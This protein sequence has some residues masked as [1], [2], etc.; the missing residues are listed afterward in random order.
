M[1]GGEKKG[2]GEGVFTVS[3]GDSSADHDIFSYPTSDP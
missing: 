2:G 3:T 1:L